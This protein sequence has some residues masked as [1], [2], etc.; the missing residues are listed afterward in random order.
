MFEDGKEFE[1]CQNVVNDLIHEY[2][3]AEKKDYL[4]I[5]LDDDYLN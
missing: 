1:E 4:E 2:K 3:D 5:G